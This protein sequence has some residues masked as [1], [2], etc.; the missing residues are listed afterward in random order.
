MLAAAIGLIAS[1]AAAVTGIAAVSRSAAALADAR[2][3]VTDIML[4][5][6]S[7][8]AVLCGIADAADDSHPP[9]HPPHDEEPEP[10]AAAAGGAAFCAAASVMPTTRTFCS[11]AGVVCGRPAVGTVCGRSAA[12]AVCGSAAGA[13]AGA[14]SN[15]GKE[16]KPSS[17]MATDLGASCKGQSAPV[18]ESAT[19]KFRG[20]MCVFPGT[21]SQT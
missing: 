12:G 2:M 11:A 21:D 4:D 17:S 9:P 16:P 10:P 8:A 3:L 13:A 19:Q 1:I 18:S 6:L 7:S 14:L 20:V 15:F 5:M